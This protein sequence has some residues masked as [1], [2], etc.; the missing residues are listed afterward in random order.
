MKIYVCNTES[1]TH[2]KPTHPHSLTIM[3][4]LRFYGYC[5]GTVRFYFFCAEGRQFRLSLSYIPSFKNPS[6]F[7]NSLPAN[8][9]T[10]PC[11]ELQAS[12][13]FTTHRPAPPPPHAPGSERVSRGVP[14]C[15]LIHSALLQSRTTSLSVVCSVTSCQWL[16]IGRIYTMEMGR[17]FRLGLVFPKQGISNLLLVFCLS[18]IPSILG[19]SQEMV[20]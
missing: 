18:L 19:L 6:H 12:L 14:L 8:L 5:V 15:P 20:P 2:P 9:E 1:Q 16:R 7:K 11:Y 17:S 13:E 4:A 3:Q 10:G